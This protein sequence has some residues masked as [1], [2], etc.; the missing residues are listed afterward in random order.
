M[1]TSETPEHGV[2]DSPDSPATRALNEVTSPERVERR[3]WRNTFAIIILAI[4]FASLFANLKFTLSLFV[5]SAL[6]LVN[7]KWLHAS[8]KDVLTASDGKRP[9]G[10]MLLFI[11]RWILVG[12]VV[13]GLHL[14]GYFDIVAM[15]AGL[16]APALAVMIEAGYV[17][18]KT[19]TQPGEHN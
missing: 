10:T 1:N 4:I 17:T 12:A 16:F 11:V 9:P 6:S 14:T 8:I 2:A 5:G 18:Y 7:F 15:L 19:I 3:I 13:Y